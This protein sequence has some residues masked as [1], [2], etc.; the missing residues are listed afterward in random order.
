MYQEE[1]MIPLDKSWHET[2]VIR[3]EVIPN[4]PGWQPQDD[5]DGEDG[6]PRAAF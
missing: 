5:S 3:E 6:K 1:V 4:K 2:A